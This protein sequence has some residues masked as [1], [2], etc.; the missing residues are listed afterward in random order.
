[1]A[2]P[3]RIECVDDRDGHDSRYSLDD[4]KIRDELG[5]S[6]AIP[7]DEGL[8]ETVEWYKANYLGQVAYY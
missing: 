6:A 4:S 7:F 3:L 2:R 1:M 8:T 5:Y